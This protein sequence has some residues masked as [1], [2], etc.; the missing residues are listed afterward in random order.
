MGKQDALGNH[1]RKTEPTGT[2]RKP[3]TLGGLETA[4]HTPPTPTTKLGHT[5]ELPAS[6]CSGA[7]TSRSGPFNNHRERAA[8]LRISKGCAVLPCLPHI[9]QSQTRKMPHTPT[10]LP[11]HYPLPTTHHLILSL[12]CYCIIISY[13]TGFLEEGR[14]RINKY[15]H[16]HFL[17]TISP[18]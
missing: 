4:T 11:T 1:S 13:L 2:R 12:S 5:E 16:E 17:E 7:V 9:L 18:D 3:Q 8:C 6:D 14:V 10:S 15:L